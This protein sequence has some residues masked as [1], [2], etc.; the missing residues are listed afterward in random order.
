MFVECGVFPRRTPA[1]CNVPG[2]DSAV[3]IA[4]LRGASPILGT[5]YKHG[6]P[7]ERAVVDFRNTLIPHYLLLK[8]KRFCDDKSPVEQLV[9]RHQVIRSRFD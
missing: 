4:P 5:I 6:A 9:R 7:L 1:G 2:S 3:Y 8:G